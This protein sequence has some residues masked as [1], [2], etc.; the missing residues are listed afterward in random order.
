MTIVAE[1]KIQFD[2]ETYLS[3]L[4]WRYGSPEM[5]RIWS[6]AEKRRTFRRIWVALAEAQCEAGLVTEAQVTDLREHQEQINIERAEAIEREIHH[7]LMAEIRTFAEQCPEGGSIIH[8][9]A[10]SMD[11]EDNADALR[12]RKRWR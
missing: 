8:L 9:G 4:T 6:E 10:T 7:D 2:H 11:I 3:P 12:L 5:R 1:E